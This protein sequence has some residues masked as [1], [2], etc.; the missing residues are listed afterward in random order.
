MNIKIKQIIAIIIGALP[1]Y[2]FNIYIN[3]TDNLNYKIDVVLFK[4]LGMVLL[5]TIFLFILNKYF[6]K[7]TIKEYSVLKSTFLY[8]IGIGFLILISYYFLLSLGQITYWRWIGEP[9]D[10]SELFLMVDN[11][12][13]NW[14]YT[15]LLAGPFVIIT[16]GFW[17]VSL[18]FMLQNLW[19]FRDDK[20]W[21]WIFI[22]IVSIFTAFINMHNGIPGVIFWFSVILTT[23]IFYY[24]Y[25][26]VIPVLL[27][28]LLFQWFDLISLWY[29]LSNH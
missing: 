11:I 13:S 23:S 18:A 1:V 22:F 4:Y 17:V 2:V 7:K 25:R 14:F 8:D 9:I 3:I 26:R 20:T 28:F 6:L 24:K 29:Y 15:I 27:A 10:Q 16:Q 12:F 5:A 21:H 19:S